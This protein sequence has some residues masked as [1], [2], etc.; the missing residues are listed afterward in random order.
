[1]EKQILAIGYYH[2][3]ETIIMTNPQLNVVT[4]LSGD[5]YR[6]EKVED[7]LIKLL[8]NNKGRVVTYQQIRERIPDLQYR[9]KSAIATAVHELRKKGFVIDTIRSTGLEYIGYKST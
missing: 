9:S 5:Y 4:D 3:G 6:Y 2:H 7:K 1:M 8:A